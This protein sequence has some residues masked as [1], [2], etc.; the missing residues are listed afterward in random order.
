MAVSRIWVGGRAFHVAAPSSRAGLIGSSGFELPTITA[1]A[2][3][4]VGD[5]YL[6]PGRETS[7]AIHSTPGS[8][9]SPGLTLVPNDASFDEGS[10]E[11]PE[12]GGR[13]LWGGGVAGSGQPGPKA[14]KTT[15]E[16]HPPED[17]G[18]HEARTSPSLQPLL[19][20]DGCTA[21]GCTA[22]DPHLIMTEPAVQVIYINMI[23]AMSH[24]KKC[25]S[26]HRL[27]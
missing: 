27:E 12:L 5:T 13:I 16:A 7:S 19:A 25:H 15:P 23:R 21:G 6:P 20:N 11:S 4:H 1:V 24:S 17:R 2:G 18:P 10:P 14:R 8:F 3:C 22:G 9:I 26:C